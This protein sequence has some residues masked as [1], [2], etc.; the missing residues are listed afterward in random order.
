MIKKILYVSLLV[1]GSTISADPL[2][3]AIDNLE[4]KPENIARDVYR[5]PYETISFFQLKPDMQVIELSPGSGWYTEILASYLRESGLLIA[6][7]FNPE[8][9]NNYLRK[10]RANFENMLMSR[11]ALKKV[12]LVN[13]DSTLAPPNSVDAVLTFRNLHN[14]LGPTMDGIFQN[15]FN[16]LKPGGIFGVVEHRAKS[17]TSFA[18][19]K[20]SGYVTENYAIEAAEK[21]GFK[22]VE[23]SNI[24][25]NPKDSATHPKG[26]WTLPPSLRMKDKDKSKYLEIGES[27]RMTLLFVKPKNS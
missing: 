26:V 21:I 14:W 19:M 15:S 3:K 27:D 12:Q 5:N 1:L 18:K 9:K 2:S 11:E 6:A 10:S 16:A 24:N 25:A 20:K 7:H 4:R 17:G 8:I 22:F 13:L 23:K